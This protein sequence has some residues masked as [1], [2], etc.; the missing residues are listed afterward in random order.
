MGDLK[1]ERMH[2][3]AVPFGMSPSDN[4][5]VIELAKMKASRAAKTLK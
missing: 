4:R 5:D 2:R 3:T 1:K